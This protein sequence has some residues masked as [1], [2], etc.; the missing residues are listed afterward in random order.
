MISVPTGTMFWEM[1]SSKASV[2]RHR[3]SPIGRVRGSSR[4]R[5]SSKLMDAKLDMDVTPQSSIIAK[6]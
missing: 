6:Q 2:A 1:G 4:H 3:F 5:I